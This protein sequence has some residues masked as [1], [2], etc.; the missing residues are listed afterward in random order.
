MMAILAGKL[1]NGTQYVVFV[2]GFL[3]TIQYS[4]RLGESNR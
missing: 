2:V 4:R 1:A 3:L